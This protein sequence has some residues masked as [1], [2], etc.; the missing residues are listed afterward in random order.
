MALK[1]GNILQSKTATVARTDTTNKLLFELPPGAQIVGVDVYGA[2]A[3]D[4]ATSATLTIQE[5]EYGEASAATFAAANA[6]TAGFQSVAGASLS[7][8]VFSRF[9]RHVKVYASYAEVG[10]ATTGGPWNV[11]VKYM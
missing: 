11:L 5:Q 10:A 2:T 3:S 8:A 4:S 6:K 9:S 1:K 7:G